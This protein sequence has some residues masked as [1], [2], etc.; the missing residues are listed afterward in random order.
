MRGRL[1]AAKALIVIEDVDIT[2]AVGKCL[3]ARSNCRP[4]QG[5]VR[6]APLRQRGRVPGTSTGSDGTSLWPYHA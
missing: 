4:I 3:P 5:F 1:T 6:P 2:D